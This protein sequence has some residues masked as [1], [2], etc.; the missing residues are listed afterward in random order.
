[1][2]EAQLEKVDSL[3][4][5]LFESPLERYLL[6]DLAF[7]AGADAVCRDAQSAI[8]AR[9]LM[10]LETMAAHID[11]LEAK[12]LVERI[13][14]EQIVI[15][16]VKAKIRI[17]TG[18][19]DWRRHDWTDFLQ[20]LLTEQGQ[21]DWVRIDALYGALATIGILVELDAEEHND[22]FELM[23]TA[24]ASLRAQGFIVDV[25]NEGSGAEQYLTSLARD[26]LASE[27]PGDSADEAKP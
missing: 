20:K 18:E 17:A 15:L 1:M 5:E 3:S 26:H 12:G 14:T 9:T 10:P 22:L 24:E 16:P 8:A 23:W 19:F 11:S 7:H 27:T 4:S 2:T 21:R 25:K 6:A 13:G